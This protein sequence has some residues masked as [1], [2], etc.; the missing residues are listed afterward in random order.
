MRNDTKRKFGSV[1]FVAII[2]L[3]GHWVDY[4]L[5][6]K[7]GALINRNHALGHGHEEAYGADAAGHGA[8]HAVVHSSEFV[9]GITAAGFIRV[10]Y[11]Y[12]VF[13]IVF[14]RS[15]YCFI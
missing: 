14:I 12:R 7:P 4:F 2:V 8:E 6:I 3:M 1:S 5:M 9:G 13:R 10:G 15:T 11:I